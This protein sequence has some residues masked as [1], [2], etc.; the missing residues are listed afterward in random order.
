MRAR[1]EVA[2]GM[3]VAKCDRNALMGGG[4]LLSDYADMRLSLC[5]GGGLTSFDDVV[6]CG[7]RLTLSQRYDMLISTSTAL[8]RLDWRKGHHNDSRLS[9]HSKASDVSVLQ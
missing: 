8:G 6:C 5:A 2:R 1:G 7:G 4:E 3:P 9:Q